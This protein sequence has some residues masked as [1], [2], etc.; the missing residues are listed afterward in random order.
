M[1]QQK[2][3]KEPPLPTAPP[4]LPEWQE[5]LLKGGQSRRASAI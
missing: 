2:N 1:R 4:N 3:Q 5:A